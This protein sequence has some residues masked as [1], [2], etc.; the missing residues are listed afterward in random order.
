MY[1]Y[2]CLGVHNGKVCFVAVGATMVGSIVFTKKTG[3]NIVKFYFL[4]NLSQTIRGDEV[5]YFA[6][7]GSTVLLLFEKGKIKLD[8]DLLANSSASK[9]IEVELYF[10][11]TN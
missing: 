10:S 7:G 4:C 9:P 5:G 8:A 1:C 11:L 2:F 6:F 3:D